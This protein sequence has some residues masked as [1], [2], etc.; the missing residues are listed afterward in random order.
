M[1]K[2]DVVGGGSIKIQ[3]VFD[4]HKHVSAAIMLSSGEGRGN[5]F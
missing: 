3:N 2:V 4:V 5:K 1:T